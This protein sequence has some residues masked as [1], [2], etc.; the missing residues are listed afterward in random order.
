MEH[1]GSDQWSDSQRKGNAAAMVARDQGVGFIFDDEPLIADGS[2]GIT[3]ARHPRYKKEHDVGVAYPAEETGVVPPNPLATINIA[4]TDQGTQTLFSDSGASPPSPL[5][6]PP[7]PMRSTP[8]THNR[9]LRLTQ[10]DDDSRVVMASV[11]DFSGGGDRLLCGSDATDGS[12]FVGK[13]NERH[14]ADRHGYFLDGVPKTECGQDRC[15]TDSIARIGVNNATFTLTQG[16]LAKD[17]HVP[18][19]ARARAPRAER[20]KIRNGNGLD[21][22]REGSSAAGIRVVENQLAHG[23]RESRPVDVFNAHLKT[24]NLIRASTA[25]LPAEILWRRDRH[26]LVRNTNHS[27]HGLVCRAGLASADLPATENKGTSSED[28]PAAH[29]AANAAS[30]STQDSTEANDIEIPPAHCLVTKPEVALKS[31]TGENQVEAS[32]EDIEE[33]VYPDAE[34]G[35]SAREGHA[36]HVP[37]TPSH[38]LREREP[39]AGEAFSADRVRAG[40][41]QRPKVGARDST[42]AMMLSLERGDRMMR[43][44]DATSRSAPTNTFDQVR[45]AKK[46]SGVFD[47]TGLSTEVT[48]DTQPGQGMK[49]PVLGRRESSALRSYPSVVDKQRAV[50]ARVLRTW[51]TDIRRYQKLDMTTLDEVPAGRMSDQSREHRRRAGGIDAPVAEPDCG[52][53]T[54]EVSAQEAGVVTRAIGAE[55]PSKSAAVV[56]PR[57]LVRPTG[58]LLSRR[59]GQSQG[60][61]STGEEIFESADGRVPSSQT[62]VATLD[63]SH[64]AVNEGDGNGVGGDSVDVDTMGGQGQVAPRKAAHDLMSPT[65]EQRQW[66]PYLYSRFSGVD[67]VSS[68]VPES[69]SNERHTSPNTSAAMITAVTDTSSPSSVRSLHST[70]VAPGT[71]PLTQFGNSGSSSGRLRRPSE[72]GQPNHLKNDGCNG[73]MV[74]ETNIMV[75]EGI[76]QHRNFTSW[77]NPRVVDSSQSAG[78]SPVGI[79]SQPLLDELPLRPNLGEVQTMAGSAKVR[80]TAPRLRDDDNGDTDRQ[81]NGMRRE[82]NYCP[83]SAKGATHGNSHRPNGGQANLSQQQQAQ[84]N[85]GVSDA[86]RAPPQSAVPSAA[87]TLASGVELTLPPRGQRQRYRSPPTNDN[88]VL[89]QPCGAGSGSDPTMGTAHAPQ[90]LCRVGPNRYHRSSPSSPRRVDITSSLTASVCGLAR[91]GSVI[92]DSISRQTAVRVHGISDGRSKGEYQPRGNCASGVGHNNCQQPPPPASRLPCGTASHDALGFGAARTPFLVSGSNRDSISSG[93]DPRTHAGVLKTTP[94]ASG[95]PLCAMTANNALREPGNN[96]G[97]VGRDARRATVLA[98]ALPLVVLHSGDGSEL[99]LLARGR[100]RVK[101]KNSS[102]ACMPDFNNPLLETWEVENPL[103]G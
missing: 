32:V 94:P 97:I 78:Y 66:P 76:P 13:A 55:Q 56:G 5:P 35:I 98:M 12:H 21:E 37:S 30:G 6:S 75:V 96:A 72:R 88:P 17:V 51:L 83:T 16:V 48:N 44:H 92:S 28:E 40:N 58:E 91:D 102:I 19:G 34:R 103:L 100:G 18:R 47:E 74:G 60:H 36:D 52:T 61:T 3:R 7:V 84:S 70:S 64:T 69:G 62:A 43:S 59:G 67:V 71:M 31:Y 27:D 29:P 87:P 77:A 15:G 39:P 49:S 33:Q 68:S 22:A 82:E 26:I 45:E 50:A 80:N 93:T 95:D 24:E 23:G 20:G 54:K 2:A 9:F 11:P 53:T 101:R 63:A 65:A 79:H 46:E 42:S 10:P 41:A 57:P 1:I 38:A 8:S 90:P 85:K 4:G 14:S 89:G 25:P 81:P 73:V 99:A 86:A